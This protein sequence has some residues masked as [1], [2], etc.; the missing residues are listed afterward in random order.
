MLAAMRAT[1]L[2]VLSL[3]AGC[4][5][6]SALVVGPVEP[7]ASRVAAR[8]AKPDPGES[9][10]RPKLVAGDSHACL[11][12]ADGALF[13][14]GDN[15]FGKLG[16][17]TDEQ[18]SAPVR[19]ALPDVHDV[20][21]SS[22]ETCVVVSG[23][24]VRCWGPLFFMR[25]LGLGPVEI[26]GV[27]GARTVAVG[28]SHACALVQGGK[29]IC[30]GA[31]HMGQMGNGTAV[32]GWQVPSLVPGLTGVVDIA[33]SG[34]ASCVVSAKGKVLCWGTAGARRSLVPTEVPGL[35]PMRA[36]R[37][38]GMSKGVACGIA[39]DG[40]VFCWG[41]D[42]SNEEQAALPE[43]REIGGWSNVVDLATGRSHVCA[44][45][46]DG[47]VSCL[48]EGAGAGRVAWQS[49]PVVVRAPGYLRSKASAVAAGSGFTCIL[50]ASGAAECLGEN[51]EGQLGIGET[52]VFS[53]PPRPV[54]GIADAVAA[55]PTVGAG[56]A[57][58]NDG[59]VFCWGSGF[60]STLWWDETWRGLPAEPIP[61]LPAV[62]A[63][64][65]GFEEGSLCA[66]TTKSDLYCF[67]AGLTRFAAGSH[68]PRPRRVVGLRDIVELSPLPDP[69]PGG[70]FAY[71]VSRS[72]SVVAVWPREG[73]RDGS[74]LDVETAA[75][76]GLADVAQ[77]AVGS[78][79]LCAR[80]RDGSVVCSKLARPFGRLSDA[81]AM[82]GLSVLEGIHDAVDI[83]MMSRVFSSALV[84]RTRGGEVL[85][86]QLD[87]QNV[88]A[89]AQPELAGAVGMSHGEGLYAVMRDGSII[90]T[91]P[92]GSFIRDGVWSLHRR[93]ELGPAVAVESSGMA[94]CAVRPGGQVA[95]WG[96][97]A[98]GACG[99]ADRVFSKEPL[100]VKLPT[101]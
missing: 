89:V 78:S 4:T 77:I 81:A 93:D 51:R 75:L 37:L 66:T 101:H 11:L 53:V 44:L 92:G 70:V 54:P 80:R 9:V 31:N 46:A 41:Q 25:G 10:R 17:G 49:T 57:L 50:D 82:P 39:V 40:R 69:D 28:M 35:P 29:V 61:D 79:R 60:T 76:P 16:D 84:V 32:Y 96:N 22:D 20:S 38:S 5:P 15:G 71:A 59:K 3:A 98:G 21:T 87:A 52:G 33:V 27:E 18:R 1:T 94:R 62:R 30:W 100:P 34:V 68:Y 86:V 6:S 65:D 26:E 55:T 88:T 45:L 8:P 7:D 99:S 67:W 24:R 36:V 85:I 12:A 19:I 74:V 42:L 90:S 2:A 13:C 47:S 14:W 58:R 64:F 83:G 63:L 23:A 56:C 73:Q 48:G 91:D 72:G 43:P 97:N 95:C